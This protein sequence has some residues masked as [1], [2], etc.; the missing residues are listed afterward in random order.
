MNIPLLLSNNCREESRNGTKNLEPSA[1]DSTTHDVVNQLSVISLCCCELRN[2]MAEKLE[3]DQLNEFKKIELAI[4][5]VAK[6]IQK[7][8]AIAREHG[9]PPDNGKSQSA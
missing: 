2:S 9:Y 6:T 4:Q 8:R 7:F 1:I 5:A 3:A